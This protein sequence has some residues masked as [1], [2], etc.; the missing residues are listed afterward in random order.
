MMIRSENWSTWKERALLMKV[1]PEEVVDALPLLLDLDPNLAA[2]IVD[3]TKNT[4]SEIRCSKGP[5]L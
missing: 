3:L 1:L 4:T 2:K 5:E